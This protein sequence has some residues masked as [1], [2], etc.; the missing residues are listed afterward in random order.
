[1]LVLRLLLLRKCPCLNLLKL[2]PMGVTHLTLTPMGVLS[3]LLMKM[4]RRKK[5]KSLWFGRTVDVT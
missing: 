2:I 3:V 5:M 1:M 4:M